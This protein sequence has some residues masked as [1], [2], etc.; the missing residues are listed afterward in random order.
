MVL[1]RASL[2]FK[3]QTPTLAGIV[4]VEITALQNEGLANSSY[5]GWGRN[6]TPRSVEIS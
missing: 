2:V 3:D 1:D 4:E 6:P 5:S